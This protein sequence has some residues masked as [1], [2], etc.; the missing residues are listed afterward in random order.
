MKKIALMAG[1]LSIFSLGYAASFEEVWNEADTKYGYKTTE[2]TVTANVV[3]ALDLEVE[4][5]EFGN[6][7]AGKLKDNPDKNGEIKVKGSANETVRLFILEGTKNLGDMNSLVINPIQLKRV[8][9]SA[10]EFVSFTP[11]FALE[12]NPETTTN[13]TTYALNGEGNLN[14]IVNGKIDAGKATTLG[15]YSNTLTVRVKYE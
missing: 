11:E 9:G 15:E 2:L 14:L 5:V 4:N 12:S 8:G 7:P 10:D 3:T 1:L 13:A 6:V